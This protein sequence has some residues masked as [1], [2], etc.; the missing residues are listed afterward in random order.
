LHKENQKQSNH[1]SA[2]KHDEIL[3]FAQDAI[4]KHIIQN[5]K[6]CYPESFKYVIQSLEA[7]GAKRLTAS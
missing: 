6:K 1:G 4:P 7:V 3:R 5:P 2:A